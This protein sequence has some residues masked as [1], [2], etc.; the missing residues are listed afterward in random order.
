MVLLRP[1]AGPE[2]VSYDGKSVVVL[3]R[4]SGGPELVFYDEKVCYMSLPLEVF[5]VSHGIHRPYVIITSSLFL[6]G[7]LFF[8]YY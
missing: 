5:L 1:S 8:F 2:L 4:P 3:R 6:T 7:S